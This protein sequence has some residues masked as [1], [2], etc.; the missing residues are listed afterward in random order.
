MEHSACRENVFAP[1]RIADAR[2]ECRIGVMSM[3]S[4][5]DRW[6]SWIGLNDGEHKMKTDDV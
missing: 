5:I 4:E 2:K 3:R 1:K 6:K